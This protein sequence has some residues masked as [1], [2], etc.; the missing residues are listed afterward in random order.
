MINP[1]KL[2]EF[3]NKWGEF[4]SRHPKFVQFI[5]TVAKNG[6]SEGSVIDVKITLPDGREIESNMKVT[7]ED[8]EFIKSLNSQ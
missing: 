3:K 5:M 7:S 8:V 6:V 4:E 2:M 1:M